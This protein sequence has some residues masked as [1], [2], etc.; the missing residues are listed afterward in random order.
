[1]ENNRSKSFYFIILN[2]LLAITS[3]YVKLSIQILNKM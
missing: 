3:I 2:D 1:M